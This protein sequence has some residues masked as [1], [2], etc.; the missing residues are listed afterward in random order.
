MASDRAFFWEV[1]RKKQPDCVLMTP[2]RKP[3]STPIE[4][5]WDRMDPAQA[6]R[7]QQDGL[8]MRHFCIQL[9]KFQLE[10][11]R[12]FCIEQPGPASS[13][14]EWLLK[15]PGVIRFLFD[16]CMTGLVVRDEMP[17]K[18]STALVTN[19]LGIAAVFSERLPSQGS[20]IWSANRE[21]VCASSFF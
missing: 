18:K 13:A 3:F 7:M 8:A 5:N 16:Q 14:M 10:N 9:A 6:S 15:Q 21:V 19:H 20:H 17:P 12:E 4:R 1:L 2:H 11:R